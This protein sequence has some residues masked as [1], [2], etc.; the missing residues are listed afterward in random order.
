M[1]RKGD[2]FDF[3]MVLLPKLVNTPGNEVAPRSDVI[4]KD[5]QYDLLYHYSPHNT[6]HMQKIYR[7]SPQKSWDLRQEGGIIVISG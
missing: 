6:E 2:P 5:L 3:D 7:P 1:Q 4:R